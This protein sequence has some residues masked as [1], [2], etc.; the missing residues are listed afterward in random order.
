M[1]AG[2]HT[3]SFAMSRIGKPMGELKMARIRCRSFWRRLAT[4]TLLMAGPLFADPALAAGRVLFRFENGRNFQGQVQKATIDRQG[5]AWIATYGQLFRVEHGRPQLVESSRSDERLLSVASGGERYAWLDSRIAPYGQFAIELFDLNR[6]GTMIA[7]LESADLPRGFG[8]LRFGN[9][10][11]SIVGVTA[12]QDAEGLGGDFRYSFWN[13]D[14]QFRDSIVLSGRRISILGENGESLLLLGESS[15]DSYV[16][17]VTPGSKITQLWSV[18]GTFRKGVLETAGQVALL[19]PAQQIDEVQVI[20]SGKVIKVLKFQ[21]PVHDLAI[22]PD[23]S[24][25][26]VATGDGELKLIELHPG[27]VSVRQ[28]PR[29]SIL[30]RY[31]VSALRFINRDS[32]A[33]GVIQFYGH[34]PFERFYGGAVQVLKISGVGPFWGEQ[35]FETAISQ[36]EPATWSPALDVSYGSDTFAAYTPAAAIFVSIK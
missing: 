17:K 27:A 25:G 31:Y 20:Q 22:T 3:E 36:S 5:V 18:K 15:A 35:I 14:G 11:Q 19:N 29:L 26:L 24:R 33:V 6:P 21:A 1:S 32:V 2:R 9:H 10:G 34:R 16:S 28:L 8:A 7:E 4:I 13:G 23:G 12:L 30:S